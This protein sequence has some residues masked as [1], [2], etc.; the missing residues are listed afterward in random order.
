MTTEALK[1]T[2][3]KIDGG[4]QPREE[5]SEQTVAEYADAIRAGESF[6]PVVVFH[7]GATYWLVDGFHRVHAHRRAGKDTIQAIVHAGTLRDAVLHS[8]AANVDHGLRRTNADKR[9]AV[10][11]MLTNELVATDEANNP[12][13]NREVARRCAVSLDLVNRLRSSLNESFSEGGS[14]SRSYTTKHG[15]QAVMK[16]GNIGRGRKVKRP[17][18]RAPGGLARNAMTPVRGH[19]TQAQKTALELPH[20]P[21]WAARGLL[22]ALGAEFVRALIP[23][24]TDCLQGT[25]E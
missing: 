1:I 22:S 20:D 17:S 6:P 14:K 18:P 24:L 9:K 5:I 2:A 19:S 25:N 12:W 10:M 8:L 16:T 13:S 21:H 23:E 15:S 3:L 4:T 11:T 7:D